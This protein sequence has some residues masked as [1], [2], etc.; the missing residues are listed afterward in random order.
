MKLKELAEA[1]KALDELSRVSGLN[2]RTSL[3]AVK[4]LDS[5]EVERRFYADQLEELCKK[6]G[7]QGESGVWNVEPY[8][9]DEK[10]RE[11]FLREYEELCSLDVDV[12]EKKLKIPGTSMGL[13]PKS[14]QVLRDFVEI[15]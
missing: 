4:L 2:M 13:T 8:H 10:T 14:L 6:Y 1:T 11:A 3:E 7:T 12:P 5:L 9:L 15:T